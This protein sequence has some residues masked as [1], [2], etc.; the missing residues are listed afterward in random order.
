MNKKP[1]PA[2]K[3]TTFKKSVEVTNPGIINMKTPV[4]DFIINENIKN[5]KFDCPKGLK[6]NI[7]Y[8]ENWALTRVFQHINSLMEGF[9]SGTII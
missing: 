9:S 7:T 2:I 3:R 5:I 1:K 8:P 4:G 6:Y